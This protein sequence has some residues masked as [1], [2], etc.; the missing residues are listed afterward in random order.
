MALRL[1]LGSLDWKPVDAFPAA[2]QSMQTVVV[3][4]EE[5]RVAYAIGGFGYAKDRAVTQSD[6]YS[7]DLNTSKWAKLSKGLPS[8][9]SQFG[10]AEWGGAVWVLG[11]LDYDDSRKE[12]DQFRHPTAVLRMDL[13]DPSQGFSEAGFEMREKRRAFAG[14]QLGSRYFLTGGIREDFQAV[15]ACEVIDLEKKQSQD[16]ACPRA[17]RLGGEMVALHDKLYLVGGTLA[18]KDGAREPTS[19]IEVYDPATNAWSTLT[20]KLPFE[21]PTHLRAYAF[22]DGLLLYTAQHESSTVQVALVNVDAVAH[23][24]NQYASISVKATPAADLPPVP[25][26]V[27]ANRPR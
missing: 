4:D 27:S 16:M 21:S 17:H 19:A 6:V 9:R 23:G 12:K 7:Y 22:H 26:K 5:H 10:V 15:T 1:D 11:G 20:E 25:V 8:A 18:G 14:A 13:R 24:E 2:R 3:G